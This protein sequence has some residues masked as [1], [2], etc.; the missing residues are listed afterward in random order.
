MRGP[1]DLRA[2]LALRRLIRARGVGV[3]HTHSSIDAWVGGIAAKSCGLALVRSRHVSIAIK[4]RRALVYRLADR[5]LTS[6]DAVADIV[7]GAGVPR[8]R[9]VAL[10]PGVDTRRFHPGISGARVRAE[11]GLSAAGVGLVANIRGS[12]GHDVFL[13]T[14]RDVLATH[15]G[16]RFVIVGEGVGFEEVRRKVT[17][18]GLDTAVVMTG[19]RRDVPDIMA[20]LD[21]LVLPSTRSEAASQVVPQALAVGTPVIATDVGGTRELLRDGVTGFVVP[22]GDAPALAAAIRRCLDDP[23]KARAMARAGGDL[24][25]ARFNLDAVMARTSAIYEELAAARLTQ[26][27]T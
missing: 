5:V 16:T 15:P 4:R 3:V 6:G 11:L 13:A 8:A 25:R 1:L 23:P 26:S 17:T 22:P 24:V 18:M 19:F 21:V 12:K 9:I 14:A 7:A 20:A 27:R 2:I 10:P